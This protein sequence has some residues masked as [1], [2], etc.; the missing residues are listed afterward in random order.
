[1]KTYK[2]WYALGII[3]MALFALSSL[4]TINVFYILLSLVSF[5]ISATY[6]EDD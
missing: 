4:Y 3:F 6:Y 5:I 2:I 1:M